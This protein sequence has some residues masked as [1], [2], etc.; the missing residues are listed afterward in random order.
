MAQTD[1]KRGI[2]R[3]RTYIKTLNTFRAASLVKLKLHVLG[4]RRLHVQEINQSRVPKHNLLN[5]IKSF[6]ASPYGVLV[7]L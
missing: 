7:L 3:M 6:V 5:A 2:K 1:S 4:E